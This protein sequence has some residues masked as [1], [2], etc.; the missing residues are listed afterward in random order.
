MLKNSFFVLGM[1]GKV[2]LRSGSRWSSPSQLSH[3]WN[4]AKAARKEMSCQHLNLLGGLLW[5]Q[6]PLITL[7]KGSWRK[8]LPSVSKNYESSRKM[9]LVMFLFTLSNTRCRKNSDS[10]LHVLWQNPSL[11]S[12]WKQRLAFCRCHAFWT[13]GDLSM[14]MLGNE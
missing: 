9:C 7:W 6:G 10:L 1:W 3:G 8:T 14:V 4:V 11:L 5:L 13:A 2:T 12:R